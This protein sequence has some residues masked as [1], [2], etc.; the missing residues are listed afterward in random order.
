MSRWRIPS[1]RGA[2][3][4]Q[5]AETCKAVDALRAH[6][7]PLLAAPSAAPLPLGP[8]RWQTAANPRGEWRDLVSDD[9]VVLHYAYA[10]PGD[11]AAK[12]RRSCPGDE[13]LAAARS[14]AEADRAKVCGSLVG[15]RAG[16][17]AVGCV[18]GKSGRQRVRACL[19]PHAPPPLQL[20]DCFVIE[21]DRAAF[22]AAAQGPAAAADF[23]WAHSVLS[24]GARVRC[25]DQQLGQQQ[26]RGKCAPGG[27]GWVGGCAAD[28]ARLLCQPAGRPPACCGQLPTVVHLLLL[29]LPPASVFLSSRAGAR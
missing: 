11:V 8:R 20:K 15:C 3:L 21:F 10:L 14:S 24:E 2:P 12:A 13:Y 29:H 18:G 17:R 16:R 28:L 22:V 27:G 1:Q 9:S 5:E 7:H 23:H 19:L 25:T 4:V 26:V 6:L